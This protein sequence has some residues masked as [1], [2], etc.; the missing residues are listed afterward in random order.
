MTVEREL[1]RLLRER[2]ARLDEIERLTKRIDKLQKQQGDDWL[3][4]QLDEVDK[5]YK[6]WPRWMR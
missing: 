3:H 5:E 1:S 2:Q 6:S 4:Q